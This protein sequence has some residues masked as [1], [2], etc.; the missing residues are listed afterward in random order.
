MPPALP[1]SSA[2]AVEASESTE[3]SAPI[4]ARRAARQRAAPPPPGASET[5]GA[6]APTCRAWPQ[7]CHH[8]ASVGIAASGR[9]PGIGH[10]FGDRENSETQFVLPPRY[11]HARAVLPLSAICR[12]PPHRSVVPPGPYYLGFAPSA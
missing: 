8:D 4:A 5:C 12:C 10:Y 11:T 1:A 7:V 9:S 2:A 6:P 3:D